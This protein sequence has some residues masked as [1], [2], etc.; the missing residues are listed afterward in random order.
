MIRPQWKHSFGSPEWFEEVK[1]SIA[2][3]RAPRLRIVSALKVRAGLMTV[4]E[5][6]AAAREGQRAASQRK[7]EQEQQEAERVAKARW[8]TPK[9]QQFIAEAIARETRR[10]LKLLTVELLEKLIAN[11][12]LD[13]HK[14]RFLWP[15]VKFFTPDAQATWLI[16]ELDTEDGDTMFGLCDLGHGYPELGYFSLKDLKTVRGRFGLPVERE[17]A[18][19]PRMS[20]SAYTDDAR[21]HGRIRD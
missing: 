9:H 5:A 3:G 17:K 19:K 18:W 16:S 1:R 21:K 20:L 7:A 10:K 6:R 13:A 15:V 8:T 4:D 11:G 12:R 2:E 14:K